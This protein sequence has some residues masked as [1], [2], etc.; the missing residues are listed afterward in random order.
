MILVIGATGNVGREL[1]RELSAAGQTVR[2]MTRDP[3]RAESLRLP[4]VEL[5]QGDLARPSSLKTAFKGVERVFLASPGGP[6]QVDEQNEAFKRAKKAGAGLLV[7]LSA[8]GV[9]ADSPSQIFR[10]HAQNELKLA[11]SGLPHVILRPN[12][13]MQNTLGYAATIREQGAFYAPLGQGRAS[14]VDVRDIAAAARAILT[15][16]VHAENEYV[17]T[18]PESITAS[19]LAEV[20]SE[21]LGRE[22]RYIPVT[23]EAAAASM[24]RSGTPEWLARDLPKIMAYWAESHNDHVSG[25]IEQLTGKPP[26]DFRQFVRENRATFE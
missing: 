2:A 1:V 9:S 12:F 14:Q 10:W 6:G 3:S 18:G 17:L 24:I 11:K 19:R 21:E 25:D 23:A 20:L 16:Q 22:V 4:G 13:F 15:G 5:A 7:K 26:R 8:M